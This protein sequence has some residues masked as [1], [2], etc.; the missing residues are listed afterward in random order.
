MKD[1]SVAINTTDA[2][3]MTMLTIQSQSNIRSKSKVYTHGNM[4]FPRAIRKR[5]RRYDRRDPVK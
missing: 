3:F 2:M 4:K 1:G 5:D